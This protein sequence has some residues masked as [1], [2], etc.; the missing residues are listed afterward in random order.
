MPLL[1]YS[2]QELLVE[3]QNIEREFLQVHRQAEVG[4]KAY[5]IG[6]KILSDFFKKCLRDYLEP[7][8]HPV[9]RKIIETA[10][11]DGTIDDYSD[12]IEG[13]PIIREI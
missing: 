1:G 11:N 12:L 10:L 3:G 13:E 8:L 2:L 7:G 6:G 5:D 9:G 4:E